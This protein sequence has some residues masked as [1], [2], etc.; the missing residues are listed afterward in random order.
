MPGPGGVTALSELADLNPLQFEDYLSRVYL[1]MVRMG[2]PSLDGLVK[3]GFDA[4]DVLR[5]ALALESRE[6]IARTGPSTWEVLPPEVA[7]PRLAA[8]MESRARFT[9]ASAAELGVLWR[10]SRRVNADD[11]FRGVEVMR[12]LAD[13]V[14]GM[15]ALWGLARTELRL[16]LD[17]SPAARQWLLHSPRDQD[18]WSPEPRVHVTYVADM[19]LVG[20][21]DVFAELERRAEAGASLR[22]GNNVPFGCAVADDTAALVDLSHY[23]PDADGSFVVRRGSAVLALAAL[24]DVAFSLA[25]PLRQTVEAHDQPPAEIPL[26]ERDRRILGLL[27]TGASD[28]MISRNLAISTRTVERR[29]RYLMDLFGAATRFQAGVMAARREW[30]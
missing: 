1:A 15:D 5:A 26:D 2:M 9:R 22:V 25:T 21:P 20:D 19:N 11:G 24:V 17:D 27:A 10:Q 18:P 12:S 8:T 3:E 4:E 28:Q 7:L 6:L 16:L 30:I 14:Q 23:A 29:V 13:V